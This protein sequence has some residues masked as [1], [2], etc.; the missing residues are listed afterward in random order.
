[1]EEGKQDYDYEITTKDFYLKLKNK[2]EVISE[3]ERIVSAIKP[4]G[5]QKRRRGRPKGTFKVKPEGAPKR[6]YRKTGK[7][8]KKP[9][10]IETPVPETK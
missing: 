9:K 1:M 4:I 5:E 8:S 6:A 7:Y 10:P 2:P 3:L